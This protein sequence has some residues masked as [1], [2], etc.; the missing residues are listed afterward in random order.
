MEL[1]LKIAQMVVPVIIMIC[2][3]WVCRR[4]QY[5]DSRGLAGLKGLIGNITLPAVL[6]NAFLTAEYNMRVLLVFA[7][8]YTGF[9]IALGFGFLTRRLVKPY[10]R[11]MPFLLTCAEGGMLGYALFAL[12]AGSG[13]TSV[14]A[15]VDI[16]QTVFAYTVFMSGLKIMDG[17]KTGV[18]DVLCS[19]ASNKACIG[20][21][22]GILLGVSGAGRVVLGSAVGGIVKDLI[23]FI[24]APTAGVILIIVGYE[25]ELKKE[26]LGPVFKT[27]CLRLGILAAV[28]AAGSFVIFTVT[29]FDKELFMAMLLMYSLPAPFIIPLY[30]DTGR[31]GAYISTTLSVGTLMTVLFFIGIAA[32]SAA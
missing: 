1:A 28:L 14:F 8:V 13:A 24:T 21:A 25:L 22:A 4:K 16:G 15:T 30:A 9:G 7:V 2:L 3:G 12:I 29:P 11:F 20:M 5:I 23:S 27:V 32:Y 17:R 6:F 26:L 10:D 18:K 19:L 31:D